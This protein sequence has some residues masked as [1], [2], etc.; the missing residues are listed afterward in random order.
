MKVFL[1]GAGAKGAMLARLLSRDGHQVTCGD[2]DAK[3]AL[4]FL[5]NGAEVTKVNAG[6]CSA[7]A[8]AAAGCDLL[9]NCVPAKFNCTVTRAALRVRSQYLDL[10]SHL[11]RN[12]SRPEQ[13]K[14]SSDFVRSG[15]SAVFNAGAAP[16]LSNLLASAATE[17][18]DS[19]DSVKI[20]LFED[21]DSDQPVSTWSA[22]GA[23]DEAISR[24]L[25]YRNGRYNLA[26]RFDEL[27]LF[28]FPS[29]IGT[30]PVV[31]AAIPAPIRGRGIDTTPITF[32]V[33]QVRGAVCALLL[34]RPGSCVRSRGV[35]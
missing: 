15:R 24:P 2:S 26:R 17:Q 25:V 20:R 16:G 1:L 31:L 29:P 34:V 8:E 9:I 33:A 6:R 18:F 19:V 12:P 14:F 5:G 32:A 21:T 13:L 23:Y 30:I 4:S 10:A 7:T 35:A 28:S 22:D 27:E 3:R 11:G